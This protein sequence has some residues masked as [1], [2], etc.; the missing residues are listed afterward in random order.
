MAR[1]AEDLDAA[2]AVLAGPESPDAKAVRFA[3]PPP[4]QKSISEYRVGFVLEDPFVP[5]C[6]ET[7]AVLEHA[8]R[9]IESAGATVKQ[10]WPDGVDF[11][12]LLDCYY[13]HIGALDFSMTPP[14]AR[15]IA[16]RNLETKVA[17]FRRGALSSF[18]EWQFENLKRLAFRE[19]W[20][21][22]FRDFDVFLSPTTFTAAVRHDTTP[23]DL[24]MVELEDGTAHPFWR[25]VTYI[26]PASLTGCPAT[27]APVGLT[28]TG[29]PVGLQIM[30]P[31]AEDAT[32]THFAAILARVVGGFQPPP[33]YRQAA[34]A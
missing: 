29:L 14:E 18:A 21:R 15:E 31:F 16:R 1:S 12:D 13:F 4:R 34:S 33:G 30:G 9:S 5:V 26:A 23:I 25:I 19:M 27:T 32:P 24:R 3:F 6:P 11:R 17:A 20:E 28:R 8:I 10:G 7:Q 22:Y 2:L